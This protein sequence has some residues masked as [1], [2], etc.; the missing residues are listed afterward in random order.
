MPDALKDAL[1]QLEA[2]ARAGWKRAQ[3]LEDERDTA[4]R[5]LYVAY[6][7]IGDLQRSLAQANRT[8]DGLNRMLE[9]ERK[10][11]SQL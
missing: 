6:A 11:S 7:T 9:D 1:E 3:L 2:H 8:I 10:L 4:R 5:E